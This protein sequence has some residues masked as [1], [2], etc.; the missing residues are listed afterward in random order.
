[1]NILFQKLNKGLDLQI[2]FDLL[3]ALLFENLFKIVKDS[4]GIFKWCKQV[5][6]LI[7]EGMEEK[8][9]AG[10]RLESEFISRFFSQLSRLE[11]IYTSVAAASTVDTWWS[12]FR[13]IIHATKIPFTGEPLEGL[14]VMGFLESRVLDFENVI[15][16][17]VNED[18]LPASTQHPSFIP[19]GI[20]K[21]FGLPTHEEQNAVTAYHFYR[22]LQRPKKIWL[23]HNTET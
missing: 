14:Q 2:Y 17:S 3:L 21:A 9:F 18:I 5:L 16:L 13:Q 11:E 8:Q 4:A 19:Y 15:M 22:L 6:Q 12:L 10:H 7:L 1:M 23:I 20:R